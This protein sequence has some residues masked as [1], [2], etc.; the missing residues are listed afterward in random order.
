MLSSPEL[1]ASQ[2]NKGGQILLTVETLITLI[3]VQRRTSPQVVSMS[4]LPTS[5]VVPHRTTLGAQPSLTPIQTS[6]MSYGP[7]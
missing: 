4:S 3:C 6:L 5:A 7:A 2:G 1:T